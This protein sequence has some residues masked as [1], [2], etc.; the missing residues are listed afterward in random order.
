MVTLLVNIMDGH[1]MSVATELEYAATM[2]G[3]AVFAGDW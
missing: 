1:G 3:L 2:C